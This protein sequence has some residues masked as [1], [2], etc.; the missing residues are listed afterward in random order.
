MEH[1]ILRTRRGIGGLISLVALII[2]FGIASV[3]FL[4][5]NSIQASFLNTGVEINNIQMDRTNER[6]DFTVLNGTGD[7]LYN[8][9]I[10]NI[11]SDKTMLHSFITINNTND[12]AVQ[13]YLNSSTIP[14]KQNIISAAEQSMFNFTNNNATHQDEKIIFVTSVGKKCLIPIPSEGS[15]QSRTC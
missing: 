6:L 11:W 9:T 8:F 12:A 1:V 13:K 10:T 15:T 14:G 2:V 3:A 7:M 4:E 5:L